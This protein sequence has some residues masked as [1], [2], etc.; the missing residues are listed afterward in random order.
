MSR[1]LFPLLIYT[2]AFTII[3]CFHYY[4]SYKAHSS[5]KNEFVELLYKSYPSSCSWLT[6]FK[7]HTSPS[8]PKRVSTLFINIPSV[9]SRDRHFRESTRELLPFRLLPRPPLPTFPPP[10]AFLRRRTVSFRNEQSG[11]RVLRCLPPPLLFWDAPYEQYT[12]ARVFLNILPACR[13]AFYCPDYFK[14]A[15]GGERKKRSAR[16]RS[17]PRSP[18]LQR[19]I[20]VLSRCLSP[21]TCYATLI[22]DSCLFE[23]VEKFVSATVSSESWS[24]AAASIT[25]VLLCAGVQRSRTTCLDTESLSSGN[26]TRR[27]YLYLIKQIE[28]RRKQLSIQPCR[29]FEGLSIRSNTLAAEASM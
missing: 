16:S 1:L 2:S 17:S 25:N 3:L 10:R 5:F 4:P 24:L 20:V 6:T 15:R 11:S 8:F 19:R 18:R 22:G 28:S 9:D 23:A 26:V 13:D 21:V 29:T 12:A 27:V 7:I 14:R